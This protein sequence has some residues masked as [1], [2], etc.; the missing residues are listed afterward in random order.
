M[1]VIAYTDGACS[2]NP[3]NI[4]NKKCPGGWAF[5]AVYNGKQHIMSGYDPDTTNNRM[6]LT[7]I[8]SLVQ[9]ILPDNDIEIHT[10]SQLIIGWLSQG[11]KRNEPTIRELCASI[12]SLI[13]VKSLTLTFVL[14][15]GHSGDPMN[16]M[17]DAIA[18]NEYKKR[19]K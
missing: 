5:I 7:A 4:P 3:K 16:D 12:D 13:L 15:K 1:L 17:V 10:D 9:N 6:E 18:V 11:W 19:Q 2:G 8:L 14:V